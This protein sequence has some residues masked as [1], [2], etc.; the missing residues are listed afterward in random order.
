MNIQ[1]AYT[2]LYVKDVPATMEFYKKAL[3]F[4]QKMLTPENE[5]FFKI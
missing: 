2:I 1:Y 5:L 3:G 4:K